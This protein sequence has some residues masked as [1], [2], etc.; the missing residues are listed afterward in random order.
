MKIRLSEPMS[1]GA[2]FVA[3]VLVRKLRALPKDPLGSHVLSVLGV[4]TQIAIEIGNAVGTPPD[5]TEIHLHA[6]DAPGAFPVFH[7]TLRVE[8]ADAFSSRLVLAGV[9]QVPLGSV[10]AAADRT[11]L[12]GAAK[13]SLRA[14]LN[15]VR[16]VVAASVM[17]GV[18]TA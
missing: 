2:P 3:P 17:A 14:L 13:R 16:S 6:L 11:L 8:P 4:A 7:G 9:Y 18:G 15:D 1:S 5:G 12:A 10:G